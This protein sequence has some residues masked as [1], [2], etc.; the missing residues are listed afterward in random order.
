M[1]N[2]KKLDGQKNE[3]AGMNSIRAACQTSTSP[4]WI[5]PAPSV[6][7]LVCEFF[8][9]SY[10]E[11]TPTESRLLRVGRRCRLLLERDGSVPE[12]AVAIVTI[13]LMCAPVAEPVA[14]T[15]VDT[16]IVLPKSIPTG[17]TARGQVDSVATSRPDTKFSD[18]EAIPSMI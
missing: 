11:E 17:T 13:G 3:R 18:P 9:Q 8:A 12:N 5:Y 6:V 16:R 1:I 15:R 10:A 2:R 14:E 7:N 4:S